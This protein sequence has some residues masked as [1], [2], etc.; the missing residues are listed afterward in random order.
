LNYFAASIKSV[1]NLLLLDS[2]SSPPPLDSIKVATTTSTREEQIQYLLAIS[3]HWH[4]N[5]GAEE[6]ET[7]KP[8]MILMSDDEGAVTQFR[9]HPLAERFRIVGTAE[10][11]A[12]TGKKPEEV[13]AGI[14][15][16]KRM[17]KVVVSAGKRGN[18]E[19][20]TRDRA[21]RRT[22]HIVGSKPHVGGS[23]S[24]WKVAQNLKKEKLKELE[25]GPAI[26]AGFVSLVSSH[27]F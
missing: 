8:T 24:H 4:A 25:K 27:S 1:N 26:P 10:E 15:L 21:L 23:H 9:S 18:E 2:P 19:R 6:E 7:R 3:E 17:A 11:S 20:K 16:E 13:E 12:E 5:V 14:L 22:G